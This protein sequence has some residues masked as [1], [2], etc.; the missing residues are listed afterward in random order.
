MDRRSF[1][2]G[3]RLCSGGSRR[4]AGR[5]SLARDYDHQCVSARRRQRHRDAALR[6]GARADFQAAGG[7]RNQS[8]RRGPGRRA[9]CRHRK[10]GRLHAAVAQQR[11]LRLRRGRQP[12]RTATENDARRFHPAGAADCRSGA[13]AGQRSTAVQDAQGLHRRRQEAPEA[14]ILISGGL[15][16]ATHLPVALLEKATGCRSFAI[17]RPMAADRRSPRFSATM[18]R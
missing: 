11:H 14:I 1:V 5:V 3:P 17:C 12:V 9:G 4:R 18:P 13:A 15:Y 10:A 2:I 6:R 16:G 7:D 8:G